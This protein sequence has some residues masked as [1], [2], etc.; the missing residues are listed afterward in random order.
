[1]ADGE[2]RA[3]DGL[4]ADTNRVRLAAKG[5]LNT[6]H[7]SR[8]ALDLR[9]D[10]WEPA[11]AEIRIR[12]VPGLVRTLGGNQLYGN[13]PEV[14]LRE[15]IQNSADA[16]RARRK[17]QGQDNSFGQIIVRPGRDET[18]QQDWIEVEDNG[19]GMSKTVLTGPLLDF[20][21][22]FWGTPRMRQ[23]F[24]GLE[25]SGMEAT[26]QF[27]IGFFSVFMWGERVRVLTRRYDR[28]MKKPG[29]SNSAGVLKSGR[30]CEELP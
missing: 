1:M 4:L 12:D 30:F 3:V 21:A 15:L 29:Y 16:I 27:G 23:E 11:D 18:E 7:A 28:A 17:L 14:P 10:G 8:L 26:G 22:T 24:P 19:I 25:A 6:D 13:R 9:T 20:G 5:V 2:L